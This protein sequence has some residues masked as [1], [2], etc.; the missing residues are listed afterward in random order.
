V[1]DIIGVLFILLIAIGIGFAWGHS[2]GYK[3][4][5]VASITGNVKYELITN[6]DSTKT[7]R[8]IND[9]K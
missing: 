4:G 3:D 8:R 2:V 6:S 7:W 9:A 5:Q 1:E